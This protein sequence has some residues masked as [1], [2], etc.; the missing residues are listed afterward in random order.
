MSQQRS[1]VWLH[2]TKTEDGVKC[3]VCD[4]KVAAKTGNTSNLMKHLIVH[5]INLRQQSCT[6]FDCMKKKTATS[7]GAQS[8]STTPVSTQPMP[9]TSPTLTVSS[10]TD[11]DDAGEGTS[12]GN[13]NVNN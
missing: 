9:P 2:F 8:A 1:K 6:V 5:G 13:I 4:K 11:E 10:V 12:S 3:N 7:G